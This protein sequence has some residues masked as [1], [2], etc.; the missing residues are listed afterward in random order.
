MNISSRH[1]YLPVFFL[2]GFVNEVGEFY[3]FNKQKYILPNKTFSPKSHFFEWDRNNVNI[4]G[5][6][7]DFI[8]KLYSHLDNTCAPTFKKLQSQTELQ[9]EPFDFFNIILFFKCFKLAN[10]YY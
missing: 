4:D 10:S 1:H 6:E 9:I 7:T 3:I 5:V 2:D 8:E